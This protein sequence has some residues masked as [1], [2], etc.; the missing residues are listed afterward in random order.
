MKRSKITILLVLLMSMVSI[1]VKASSGQT[2]NGDGKTL[3]FNYVNNNTAV[4]ITYRG[5]GN[6]NYNYSVY[7]GDINIPESITIA[8]TTYPVIGID[9]EAFRK[10]TGLTSVTIPNSV[11]YIGD[12]AFSGCI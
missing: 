4:Y 8:E 10:C 7:S 9:E 12:Y 5:D 1:Q 3:Y 2:L 11:T 6:E